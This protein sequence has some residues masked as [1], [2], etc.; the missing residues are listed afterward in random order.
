[1]ISWHLFPYFAYSAIFL[2][3]LGLLCDF[4]LKR[5]SFWSKLSLPMIVLGSLGI[6]LFIAGLWLTLERPPM[7]TMGETRL[8]YA[9]IIPW[10]GLLVRFRM[11]IRW[12]LPYC[13]TMGTVFLMVNLFHP[14]YYDKT[15]MPALQSPWFV[16]HV[17]L[18]MV[19]YA[20]CAGSALVAGHALYLKQR[21]RDVAT[22]LHTADQLVKLG[23]AMITIG[24]LFGAM[25]AKVAWGH[26]WT[27]DPKETWAYLTWS[28]YILYMHVRH[29]HP[30]AV[31][32]ACW[33][34]L[35]SFFLLLTTW[36]GVN[37]LPSAQN[38]IHTYTRSK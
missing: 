33:I 13:L 11:R 26:F 19:G 14:D 9:C 35:V 15:L 38:S 25:W 12:L 22:S 34:L 31:R 18:Y 23:F 6:T 32:S 30:R 17:I 2:W 36:F 16:P 8:W 27:W 10:V 21:Q 3:S 5:N 29:A 24:M 4:L 28:G 1:M 20:I 7:R 37:Y